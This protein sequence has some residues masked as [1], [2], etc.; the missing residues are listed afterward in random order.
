MLSIP[1]LFN[2]TEASVVP[3]S[4]VDPPPPPPPPDDDDDE[5]ELFL[6]K[7]TDNPIVK[8]MAIKQ[9]HEKVIFFFLFLT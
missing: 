4:N 9:A 8:T 1:S 7:P 5:L 2:P 6:V 3:T